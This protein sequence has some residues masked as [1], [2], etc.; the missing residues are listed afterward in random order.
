MS[1]RIPTLLPKFEQYPQPKKRV[2][3][4]SL[5]ITPSE[6]D[7]LSKL[8]NDNAK[9]LIYIMQLLKAKSIGIDS[10]QGGTPIQKAR[11]QAAHVIP[12]AL[13][14]KANIV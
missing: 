3:N 11:L 7:M 14:M 1:S 6:L 5:N 13:N 8:K 12:Y 10:I 2:F 4:S 9:V